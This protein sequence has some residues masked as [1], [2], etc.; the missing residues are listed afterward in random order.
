LSL[1]HASGLLL[2]TG[3]AL[4]CRVGSP[5]RRQ[6]AVQLLLDEPRIFQQAQ[7]LGPDHRVQQ[8]LMG[9]PYCPAR[10]QQAYVRKKSKPEE[11]VGGDS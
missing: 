2:Q 1:V 3:L 8:I 5:G 11:I 4:A 10:H 9:S 6:P 7:D